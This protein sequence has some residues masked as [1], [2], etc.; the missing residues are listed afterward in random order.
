MFLKEGATLLHPS[1]KTW[2]NPF[3]ETAPPLQLADH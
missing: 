2:E 1:S 3:S